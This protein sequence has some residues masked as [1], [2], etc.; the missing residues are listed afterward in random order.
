MK[1]T[2]G[3]W[4]TRRNSKPHRRVHWRD[5][6]GPRIYT[7]PPTCESVPKGPN[8]LVG[9]GGSDWK[10][11]ES[12]AKGIVASLTT[13]P[14]TGPLPHRQ[15]HYTARWV[16]PPWWIPKAPRLTTDSLRP[17]KK[18]YGPNERIDQTFRK[19]RTARKIDN[20]SEFKML[21]SQDAHRNGWV[22]SQNGGKSEGYEKWNK[23]KHMGNQ[24]RR[25]GN[26]DSRQQFATKIRNKH[27]TK[28]E[29]R[30]KNSKKWGEA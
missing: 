15:G 5:S 6:Q 2:C 13:P 28:T 24:Q 22:W 11:A 29:W 30:H 4:G 10:L 3:G 20:L 23:G 14:Q 12:Q 8:L 27:P 7:N 9:S 1:I 16:A 25:K 19:N 21:V 17:K 26:Q 18:K